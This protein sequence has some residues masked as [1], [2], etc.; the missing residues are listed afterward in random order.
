MAIHSFGGQRELAE[1]PISREERPRP[2]V[3]GRSDRAIG[4]AW[5]LKL[6]DSGAET[7]KQESDLAMSDL[8]ALRAEYKALLESWE[9]AFAMGHGCTVGDHPDFRAVRQRADDLRA[10]IAEHSP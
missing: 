6:S 3:A 7:P 5:P 10:R 1:D 9:Y 4:D 2:A 8:D